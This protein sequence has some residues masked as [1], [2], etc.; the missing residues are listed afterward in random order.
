MAKYDLGVA[1]FVGCN[2]RVY[3]PDCVKEAP[4]LK[5]LEG[6]VDLYYDFDSGEWQWFVGDQP[7][8]K[9]LKGKTVRLEILSSS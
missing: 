7:V 5:V 4:S 9:A 1:G 6:E 8:T 3:E 2:L